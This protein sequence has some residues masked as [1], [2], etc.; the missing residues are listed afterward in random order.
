MF[1]LLLSLVINMKKIIL[2]PVFALVYNLCFA[3]EL[4]FAVNNT[5]RKPITKEVLIE[6]QS[7]SDINPGFPASWIQESEYISTKINVVY[8]GDSLFAMGKN[9]RLN[10]EQKSLLNQVDSGTSIQIEV[11]YNEQ[12]AATG[13]T[14][15]RTM[16]FKRSLL[17]KSEAL[18]AGGE[19]K[20]SRYVLD[21]I[22][23]KI[24]GINAKAF[25]MAIVSFEINVEGQIKNASI[26]KTSD[27]ETVDSLLMDAIENMPHW[28][29][30]IDASG[31]PINQAFELAVGTFIGC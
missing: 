30:A 26:K 11:Q 31:Q 10:H 8:N 14:E 25:E 18:F 2:I 29:P 5:F 7:L 17:P 16:K 27:N 12:N 6:A 13:K 4:Q 28:A 3:Q 20:M 19:D 15:L 24:K 9:H 21:E 23:E 22:V 1:I